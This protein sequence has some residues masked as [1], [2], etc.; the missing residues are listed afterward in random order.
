MKIKNKYNKKDYR[1]FGQKNIENSLGV[2]YH[3]NSKLSSFE[4]RKLSESIEKMSNP[5]YLERSL[6]PYKRYA[7]TKKTSL[8]NYESFKED[9]AL[10]K[11]FINRRSTREYDSNHK[12]SLSELSYLL[13][14][15]YGV[16]K[17]QKIDGIE[18][19]LG[20][21]NIPSPGALYP[22]EIY[23]V[24]IR[25]HLENGLY[26]YRPDENELELIKVGDF[27]DDLLEYLIVKPSIHLKGASGV[28]ITTGVIERLLI[29][30]EERSYRFMMLESG[31]LG[32]A[33][34]LFMENI[35][36]GSCWVGAYYDHKINDFLEIDGVFE[37]VNNVI[38]FGKKNEK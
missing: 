22:L 7:N 13:R 31:M 36:L 30:Y 21:R 26:H 28:I 18:G 32:L 1:D 38:V 3:E 10:D 14:G 4:S 24:I 16:T 20:L 9:D 37:S 23:I 8:K 5:Y 27:I 29:K 6:Q 19:T 33:L 15:A 34:N 25:G 2:F 11:A 35:G 17:K 12:V